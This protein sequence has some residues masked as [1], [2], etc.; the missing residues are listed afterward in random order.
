M[1]ELA[2]VIRDLR[3]ELVEAMK[4][5]RDESLQ[6]ALGPIEI[7]LTIVVEKKG[8]TGAKVRF[9]VVEV[10]GEAGVSKSGT[11][12]IKLVLQPELT[13]SSGPVKVTDEAAPKER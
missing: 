8:G 9:W 10:G 5:G 1:I 6:F 12:R 2:D 11:Q 13:G 4:V 3:A 7:E